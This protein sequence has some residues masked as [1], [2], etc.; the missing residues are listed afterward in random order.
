[1]WGLP[2]WTTPWSSYADAIEGRWEDRKLGSQ[3]MHVVLPKASIIPWTFMSHIPISYV[4]KDNST[5]RCCPFHRTITVLIIIWIISEFASLFVPI[6][7]FLLLYGLRVCG[8]K[9]DFSGTPRK[10]LRKF[11]HA[12]A[13][14]FAAPSC[15]NHTRFNSAGSSFHRRRRFSTYGEIGL[16]GYCSTLCFNGNTFWWR[17]TLWWYSNFLTVK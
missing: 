4:E 1:M 13:V 16:I 3:K 15:W 17:H 6:V 12:N 14:W 9:L 2:P 8:S 7:R 10:G 5:L 11:I